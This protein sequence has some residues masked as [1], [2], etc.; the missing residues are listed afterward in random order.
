MGV[1]RYN[2]NQK[3]LL[4][5]SKYKQN[6]IYTFWRRQKDWM[7]STLF[8]KFFI[9][10]LYRFLILFHIRSYEM[11]KQEKTLTDPDLDSSS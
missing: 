3:I 2:R 6:N 11:I 9:V 1:P 5:F 7:E 10:S 8:Q 4:P